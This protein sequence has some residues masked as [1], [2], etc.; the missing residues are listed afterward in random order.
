MEHGT[1]RRWSA[2]L[3]SGLYTIGTGV[4]TAALV[5]ELASQTDP[6][7]RAGLTTAPV[8]AIVLGI[9]LLVRALPRLARTSRLRR[10]AIRVRGALPEEF[11]LLYEYLPHDSG[12]DAVDLVLVGPTGVFA[13]VVCEASGSVSCYDDTWYRRQG[14]AAWRLRE[15]PS[16]V[17]HRNATR[18]RAD[19]Q[20]GGFVR[21]A[22]EAM[23]VFPYADVAEISGCSAAIAQG[24]DAMI[25]QVRHW[26]RAPL[27]DQRARAIARTL[28]GTLGIAS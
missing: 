18:L 13:V 21:T 1:P 16:R 28:S 8:A 4:A 5:A 12:D 26:N 15:S 11:A 27:S 17:A 7:V 9:V 23:V 20:S 6:R 10:L 24:V 2:W 22:V 14:A 3:R 25:D 19:V